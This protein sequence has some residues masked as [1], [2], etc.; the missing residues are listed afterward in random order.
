MM[1]IQEMKKCYMIQKKS[2]LQICNVPCWI[3]VKLNKNLSSVAFTFPFSF[4]AVPLPKVHCNHLN[5]TWITFLLAYIPTS[6]FQEIANFISSV[7]TLQCSLFWKR[8]SSNITNQ[9][10]NHLLWNMKVH[11]LVHYPYPEPNE[12]SPLYHNPISLRFILILSSHLCLDLPSG[13]FPSDLTKILYP[14][15]SY[16]CWPP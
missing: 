10:T 7:H 13:L 16:V 1:K 12:T 3:I 15:L 11:Y 6:N 2:A 9:L 8:D 14:F 4:I 5:L